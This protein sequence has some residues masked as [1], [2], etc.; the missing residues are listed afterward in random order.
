MSRGLTRPHGALS[1]GSIQEATEKKAT[2]G[3]CW[4]GAVVPVPVHSGCC[5]RTTVGVWW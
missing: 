4:E 3:L 1:Y 2:T 5:V